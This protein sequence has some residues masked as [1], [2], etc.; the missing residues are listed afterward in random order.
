M[1]A[2]RLDRALR[3]GLLQLAGRDRGAGTLESARLALYERASV[4][5]LSSAERLE[6]GPNLSVLYQEVVEEKKKRTI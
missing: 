6:Y 5:A 3:A 1:K 2:T 4:A